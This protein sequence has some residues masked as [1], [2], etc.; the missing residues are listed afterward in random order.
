MLNF[1]IATSVDVEHLFSRC[2][3][4][5]SH[6]RNGLSA[7]TTRAILCLGSW[8]LL[9]LIKDGDIVAAANLPDL[10]GDESDYEAEEG[11]DAISLFQKTST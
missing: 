4:V 9:G 6:V 2:R 3:L 8:S 5:L 11:W 10:E 1:G 7:Q